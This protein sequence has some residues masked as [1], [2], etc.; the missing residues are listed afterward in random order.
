M[1][2]GRV[3]PGDGG[4]VMR[5]N[6]DDGEIVELVDANE[7]CGE[8]AAVI[9]GDVDFHGAIDDVIVGEDVAVGRE[10]DA[11]TDA[12]LN[13]LLLGHALHAALGTE[14]EEAAELG[15]QVLQ[16][17][18]GVGAAVRTAVF[19]GLVVTARGNRD[20][21]DGGRNPGSYG[22]NSIIE[23]N[24]GRD[25]RVVK[26]SSRAKCRGSAGGMNLIVANEERAA[27]EEGCSHSAD[28][29]ELFGFCY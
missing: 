7:F 26:R 15:R 19:V 22:F 14:S 18:V 29:R 27:E 4:Q 25:A 13:L 24:K 28:K 5:V 9:E 3:T 16:T 20:V 12:V 6:L 11:A 23:R 17:T 21:D 1:Q 2:F 10:D 8:D